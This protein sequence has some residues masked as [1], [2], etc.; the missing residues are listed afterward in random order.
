MRMKEKTTAVLL[1]A[2][3]MIS[4]FAGMAMA[5]MTID[6][7]YEDTSE[8]TTD[9]FKVGTH[10]LHVQLNA[11]EAHSGQV[12]VEILLDTPILMEN[13]IEFKFWENVTNAGGP[14]SIGACAGLLIDTTNSSGGDPD[15]NWVWEDDVQILFEA[16]GPPINAWTQED[17]TSRFGFDK[18]GPAGN[19]HGEESFTLAELQVMYAGKNILGV[20]VLV[21]WGNYED[22]EGYWDDVI[23]NGVTYDFEPEPEPEPKPEPVRKPRR[24]GM[25]LY[26]GFNMGTMWMVPN[27]LIAIFTDDVPYETAYQIVITV[28]NVDGPTF[29]K[30]LYLSPSYDW[31]AIY[32]PGGLFPEDYTVT[33][34]TELALLPYVVASS[35]YGVE[36]DFNP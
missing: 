23:V 36:R 1:I 19:I 17:V 12:N 31:V 25:V 11:T 10:S 26:E 6:E 14:I 22:Y 29:E 5:D 15:G 34:Q 16:Y 28:G 18:A 9:E 8:W 32:L 13:L 21:G 30:T 2:I 20:N 33:V 7:T 24:R 27:K 35:Q 3:F 4:A